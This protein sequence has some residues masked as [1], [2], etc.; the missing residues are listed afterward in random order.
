MVRELFDG[1]RDFY[2]RHEG[3]DSAPAFSAAMA[4]SVLLCLN[5]T[6]V[7]MIVDILVHGRLTIVDWMLG[8]KAVVVI[9]AS[10]IGWAHV[11]FAKRAGLYDK[12]GAPLSATWRWKFLSYCLITGVLA[13]ASGVLAYLTVTE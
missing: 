3:A 10:A 6:T 1:L 11:A 4:L 2:S 12:T 9:S 7:S 5:I 13:V 8:H